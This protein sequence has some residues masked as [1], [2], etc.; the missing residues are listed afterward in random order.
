MDIFIALADPHRRHILSLLLN[1]EATVNALVDNLGLS[2]PSVS[3]HLR[4]LREHRLVSQRIDGQRRWYGVNPDALQ[5]LDDWLHP[6]R[7]RWS[8]RLDALG[9]QLDASAQAPNPTPSQQPRTVKGD[10]K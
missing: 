1:G 4:V 8:A 7:Q 3:K 6:F 2:Q 9:E 10:R 5:E